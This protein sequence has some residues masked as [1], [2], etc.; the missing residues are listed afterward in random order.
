[1][2]ASQSQQALEELLIKTGDTLD[3]LTVKRAFSLMCDFYRSHRAEDAPVGNDGDMLLYEWGT[4]DWGQGRY[5]QLTVI[6]QFIVANGED[7]HIWQLALILKFLP[8][9]ALVKL[10]SG[11]KWCP[12]PSSHSLEL[13][14]EF[15]RGSE[16][17]QTANG[18][19]PAKIELTYSNVG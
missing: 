6:R 2:K 15:V 17:F 8:S 5:F 1:M 7:E 9:D 4:Y 12:D 19:D 11:N 16:A 10:K 18:L 14:E 13:F 3:S